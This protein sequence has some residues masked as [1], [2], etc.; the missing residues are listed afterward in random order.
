MEHWWNDSDK[1]NQST[2]TETSS[3]ISSHT[4]N[5]TWTEFG[6]SPREG[7]DRPAPEKCHGHIIVRNYDV[8]MLDSL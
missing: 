3:S 2:W 6:S 8:C 5:L 4:I 1:G 7:N